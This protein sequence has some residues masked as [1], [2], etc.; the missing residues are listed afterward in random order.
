MSIYSV[1]IRLN[2][3]LLMA[4]RQLVVHNELLGVMVDGEFEALTNFSFEI[5]EE[6]VKARKW[7]GYLANI[8]RHHPPANG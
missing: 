7:S 5:T 4:F 8:R 6:H 2:Q 3:W 1:S